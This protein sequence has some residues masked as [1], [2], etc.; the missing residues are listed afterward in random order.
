MPLTPQDFVS[1]WKRSTGREKQTYQQHFL[2][3]CELVGHPKKLDE[4]VFA[5]YGWTR[6]LSDEEILEKLLAMN[7]ERSKQELEI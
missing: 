4:V 2:D 7:L 5:A 6:Y 1:K 3:L